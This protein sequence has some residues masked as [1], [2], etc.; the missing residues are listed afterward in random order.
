MSKKSEYSGI[1]KRTKSLLSGGENKAVDYKDRI[2]GLHTEDL[3]AFANS[4]NGGTILIGVKEEKSKNGSQIG[5]PIGCP[6]GDKSKLQIM[7]KALSCSPPVQLELFVENLSKKPFYRIEIPSGVRKPHSTNSGTYKI[8]EDG[9]NHPLLPEQLLSIFLDR[10]GEKFR[11]RF[12]QAAGE[13]EG[14]M[15]HALSVV[16]E[17]ELAITSKIEEISSSMGWAEDDA[18]NARHTIEDVDRTVN[19][20]ASTVKRDQERIKSLLKHLDAKDPIIEKAK[21]EILEHLTAQFKENEE[22]FLSIKKGESIK[23]SGDSV[24]ELNKEILKELVS[25]A[26]SIVDKNE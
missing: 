4:K 25:Q 18:N 16:N 21:K 6:I 1:T 23:L 26:I 7:G 17:L 22:L 9:R 15:N 12:S 10:E 11:D 2:K 24:E 8:R 19:T 3:V 14:Q 13:L 5:V 20:I